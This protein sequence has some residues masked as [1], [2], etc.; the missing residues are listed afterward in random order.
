MCLPMTLL[1]EPT[2]IPKQLTKNNEDDGFQ[3]SD[4]CLTAALCVLI[5]VAIAI[6]SVLLINFLQN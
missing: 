1:L 2:S 6:F 3:Y 4:R 5:I